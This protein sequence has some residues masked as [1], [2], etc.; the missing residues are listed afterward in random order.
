[1]T[2]IKVRVNKDLK[3]ISYAEHWHT[4]I[5]LLDRAKNERKGSYHQHL[6]CITFVAFTL[7]AFLN[8]IG[9]ELFNSWEDLEQL[10][11]RGKIY[12]IAEKL[13]LD[14]DYGSMPWQIVPELVA[15]RNKVAHGKNERLFEEVIL[16]Q[17][18]YD[19]Y[20][21]ESL[22]SNWQNTATLLGAEKFIKHVED[23][24]TK[25]WVTSGHNKATIFTLGI[26]SGSATLEP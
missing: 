23:L 7:E 11:V 5:C 26:Q 24:C 3:L 19:E 21:N 10:N 12:V 14:I 1:M 17:D 6:A 2:Q 4:A 9:E 15:F 22:K 20:L 16:P 8:H 25:I 13:K 18:K